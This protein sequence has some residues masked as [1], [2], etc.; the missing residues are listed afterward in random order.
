MKSRHTCLLNQESRRWE[1]KGYTLNMFCLRSELFRRY[2]DEIPIHPFRWQK[3]SR[4]NSEKLC[5]EGDR[6]QVSDCHQVELFLLY[7][8]S[9]NQLNETCAVKNILFSHDIQLLLEKSR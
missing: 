3:Y 7:Y 2:F 9:H 1:F 5:R 4:L 6:Y 8:Q